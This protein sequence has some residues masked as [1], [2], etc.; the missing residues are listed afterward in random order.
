[1]LRSIQYL[2]F[3]AASLVVLHHVSASSQSFLQFPA[4]ASGVD[5]FFVISGFIMVFITEKKE[6]S[7]FEFFRHRIARVVPSYW[8]VTVALALALLLLPGAFALS[9]FS[10]PHFLAS[11]LFL[12]YRHPGTGDITPLYGP[13]WTLNYEFFFYSLFAIAL[14][15]NARYRALLVS[16]ALIL[17]A[18]IGFMWPSDRVAFGF[19]TNPI[20]LEFVYGMLIGQIICRGARV[21]SSASITLIA[22][23]VLG[24]LAAA[25]YWPILMF[26][27]ERFLVWG[28]PAALLVAG[29]I[30]LELNRGIK[31][32]NLLLLLGNASYAIYVTHFTLVNGLT[33]VWTRVGGTAGLAFFI[34]SFVAA[35]S[36]GVL[37]YFTIERPLVAYCS[38]KSA[39]AKLT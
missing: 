4:G 22:L 38:Q 3:T 37:F 12:P 35:I 24:L 34:I 23:G 29:S 6:R 13:G 11:M 20:S 33:K 2:R 8:V 18:G 27:N 21:G 19:Y 14:A 25:L 10:F 7:S 16:A 31:S 26:S 17:A 39:K 28:L 36:I 32:S 30:F 9:K 15:I 1:M 5:V